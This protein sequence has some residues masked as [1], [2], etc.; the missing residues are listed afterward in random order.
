SSASKT[1]HGLKDEYEMLT[2]SEKEAKIQLQENYDN[3][4]DDLAAFKKQVELLKEQNYNLR[5]Y[6]GVIGKFR[7][8]KRFIVNAF[9]RSSS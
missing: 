4:R 8:M 1:I 6:G 3:L 2:R 5:Y 9:R 7:R